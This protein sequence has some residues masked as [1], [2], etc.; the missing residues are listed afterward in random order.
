[1]GVEQRTFT[2]QEI[3][4]R[5]LLS[6][7][8]EAC[9]IIEEGIAYRASG[10]DLMWLYGFGFP[11]YRGGLRFWADQIG[12]C[13]VYNQIAAW[14]QPYGD[15]WKPSAPLRRIAESGTPFRAAT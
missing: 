15:R 4:R 10:I 6:S 7:V 8:N 3:L 5:L 11:R 2:D 1:M 12:S 14:H 9:R 13:E